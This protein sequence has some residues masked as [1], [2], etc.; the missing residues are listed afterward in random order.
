MASTNAWILVPLVP[1]RYAPI[2][3]LPWPGASECSAPRN[4]AKPS[5]IIMAP[6][7]PSALEIRSENAS[8]P[9]PPSSPGSV[10]GKVAASTSVDATKSN[11]TDRVSG[12]SDGSG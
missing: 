1:T 7:P 4:A 3:V 11:V 2:T 8:P 12:F 6:I 5:A 9:S 10:V